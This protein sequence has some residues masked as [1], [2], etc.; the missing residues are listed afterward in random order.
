MEE[1]MRCIPTNQCPDHQVSSRSIGDPQGTL[2][3]N[4]V[5]RRHSGSDSTLGRLVSTVGS[6]KSAGSLVAFSKV[7]SLIDRP[8]SVLKC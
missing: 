5:T 8:K 1:I 3:T 4:H 6:E 2:E 7:T